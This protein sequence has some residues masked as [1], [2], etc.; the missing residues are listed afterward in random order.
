M[1]GSRVR[2]PAGSQEWRTKVRLF[3]FF[4][5]KQSFAGRFA[6]PEKRNRVRKSDIKYTFCSRLG[7]FCLVGCVFTRPIASCFPLIPSRRRA[8]FYEGSCGRGALTDTARWRAKI[9]G[10]SMRRE[11]KLPVEHSLAPQDVNMEGVRIS[12]SSDIILC[13]L[14]QTVEKDATFGFIRTSIYSEFQDSRLLNC[15]CILI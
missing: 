1:L 12:G 9:S 5:E 4:V 15:N 10:G 8:L 7:T 14:L 3:C 11:C 2:A 6:W 13:N